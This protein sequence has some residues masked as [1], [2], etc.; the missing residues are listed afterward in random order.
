MEPARKRLSE[1][2]PRSGGVARDLKRLKSE[3]AAT[4]AELREFLGQMKGKSPQE[5]LGLVAESGLARSILLATLLFVVL[6]V[7]LTVG[8][9][10]LAQSGADESAPVA[11][12]ATASEVNAATPAEPEPAKQ[13]GEGASAAVD[14][15]AAEAGA[16]PD[17]DRAIDAMGIGE[18]RVADP[19]DNP[20]ENKIDGLLDGIE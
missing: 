11:D 13:P 7:A 1:T 19:D 3:G 20:L 5:V 12:Q 10:L 6:L 18:T 16:P 4:V 17:A 2:E 9:Y 15:S 14:P 8:P